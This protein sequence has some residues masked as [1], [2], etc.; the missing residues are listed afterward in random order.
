[1]RCLPIPSQTRCSGERPTCNRCTRLRRNCV[2]SNDR[3]TRR[4]SPFIT[5]SIHTDRSPSSPPISAPKR[6]SRGS[7]VIATPGNRPNPTPLLLSDYP[8]EASYLG[9][10]E[11]L[12]YTLVEVYFENAY[13]ASLLLH[14]GLFLESLR[15]GNATPHVVLSVCAWA[16]KYLNAYCWCVKVY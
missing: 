5:A 8:R 14:K 3:P 4:K 12:I 6:K 11:S 7:G 1:M 9:I 15:A 10:S 2:Y 16:A 13:N